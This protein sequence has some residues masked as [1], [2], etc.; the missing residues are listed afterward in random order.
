MQELLKK[1]VY[2]EEFLVAF[3]DILKKFV[4]E[5]D[6]MQNMEAIRL[7]QELLKSINS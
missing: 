2:S 1:D 6:D 5:Y 3:H 7:A 4:E